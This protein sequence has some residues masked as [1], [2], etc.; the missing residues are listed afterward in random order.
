MEAMVLGVGSSTGATVDKPAALGIKLC[1][2]GWGQ[3]TDSDDEDPNGEGWVEKGAR[4]GDDKDGAA[5]A[6]AAAGVGGQ[7]GTGTTGR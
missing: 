2:P 1:S 4:A 5:T 6:T 3:A 7:R